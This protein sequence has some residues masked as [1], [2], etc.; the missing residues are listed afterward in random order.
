MLFVPYVTDT[1]TILSNILV[2][3]SISVLN[4][5]NKTNIV[6][7]PR[8]LPK[9]ILFKGVLLF[10]IMDTVSSNIKS[11]AKFRNNNKS[12]YIFIITHHV[13]V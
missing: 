7:E 9:N 5:I 12:M 1:I 13:I 10:R 8:M 2:M 4:G 11:N 3:K 6:N